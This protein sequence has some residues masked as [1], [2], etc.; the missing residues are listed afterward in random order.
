ML[1][2]I[3]RNT[4]AIFNPAALFELASKGIPNFA[5]TMFDAKTVY[6][7]FLFSALDAAA[8]QAFLR[9]GSRHGS[10]EGM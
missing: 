3:L 1:S 7:L 2:N 6:S 5:E 4:S 10:Q 8:D 9:T